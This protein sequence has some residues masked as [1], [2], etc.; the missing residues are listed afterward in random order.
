MMTTFALSE[1]IFK[2]NRPGEG[3]YDRR[4]R[5]L[6]LTGSY[7]ANLVENGDEAN[8]LLQSF[9]KRFGFPQTLTWPVVEKAVK[10]DY[11]NEASPKTIAMLEKGMQYPFLE[12]NPANSSVGFRESVREALDVLKTSN[13]PIA[14]ATFDAIVSGRVLVDELGDLTRGDFLQVR[15]EFAR[16]GVNL[17]KDGFYDLHDETSE[18][19]RAITHDMDGYM[20]DN[21]VYITE[22]Q[23]AQG[24]AST[25]VHEVNHI[26]NESEENYRGDKSILREEYRAFYAEAAFR[27]EDVS[28]PD[29]CRRIKQGVIEDYGLEGV[30][31]DDVPDIPPG[32][33]IP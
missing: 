29:V 28:D 10:A 2:K 13:T 5:S 24:L 27:G 16:E 30:T 26:L 18:V 14:K 20:W 22:G 21:R 19:S 6:A 25:L 17:A 7:V 31:P 8:D 15:K 32:T 11:D 3:D 1:H 12:V 4:M 23:D 9:A 33:L